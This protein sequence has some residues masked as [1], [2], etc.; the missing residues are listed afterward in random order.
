M[1]EGPEQRPQTGESLVLWLRQSTGEEKQKTRSE[2]ESDIVKVIVRPPA[3]TRMDA[4]EPWSPRLPSP[5][6]AAAALG[7]Q[8]A[9]LS[10]EAAT[11]A[12]DTP[13]AP[14]GS[15]VQMRPQAPGQSP[16]Q[17]H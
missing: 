12:E 14:R 4:R 13:A 3:S 8:E 11:A 5:V 6:C 16:G 15:P 9:T 1:E 17:T 7:T 10:S 2:N